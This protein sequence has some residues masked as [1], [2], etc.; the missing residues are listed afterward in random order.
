MNTP[1]KKRKYCLHIK[2]DP[3]AHKKID[4]FAA[5][6]K[7]EDFHYYFDL[8]NYIAYGQMNIILT[9]LGLPA[10]F[11]LLWIFGAR[12]LWFGI[13]GFFWLNLLFFFMS[14]TRNAQYVLKT[15]HREDPLRWRAVSN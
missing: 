5:E 15:L 10:S 9:I 3:V 2:H 14:L 8:C 6:E 4:A 7:R 11:F 13:A 1:E 12:P